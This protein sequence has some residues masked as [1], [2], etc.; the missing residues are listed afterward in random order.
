[1][2]SAAVRRSSIWSSARRPII[3]CR[4]WWRGRC[5]AGGRGVVDTSFPEEPK[6]DHLPQART[7]QGVS[8]F[9]TVQEGCDKFC[10]FCVVPYTRGAEYSRPAAQILDEARRLIAGGARE[11]TLLGQNVNAYHGEGPDGSEWGLGD[12]IRALADI[13]GLDRIRY[14]TS[15]PRDVDDELIAAHRD[16][17]Q[18]MPFLHLP[19]QSGSDHVLAAMNR[20][21]T[22]R[23]LPAHRRAA[24][25]GA[26]GSRAVHRSD[27]RV[28]RRDRRRI[29]GRRSISSARSALPR[30]FRSNTRR[31]PALPRH[32]PQIRS[33][34]RSRSSGSPTCRSCWRGSSASSTRLAS[35]ASCRCCWKSRGGTK[36]SWSAAA[37]I[38][39]VSISPLPTTG[40]AMSSRP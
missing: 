19:V 3:G 24:A 30:R 2:R 15:H 40:L 38:C 32:R 18:L 34:T 23:R 11:I 33:R 21:H 1:M 12:L 8:A 22:A 35:G 14:T 20:R 5:E 9:V 27:R 36:A 6:F 16:V 13:P 7:E 4:R 29:F 39:R 31:A 28:S 37:P 17:P 25:R 10:T 26:A